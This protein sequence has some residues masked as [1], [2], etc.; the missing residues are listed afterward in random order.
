MMR[1]YLKE[2]DLVS[3]EVQQIHH[4]GVLSLHTRSLKY[5]KLAQG[6]LLTVILQKFLYNI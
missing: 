4:D 5:G 3:A 1:D 2:G 6:I